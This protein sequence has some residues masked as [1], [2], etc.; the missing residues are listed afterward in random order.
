MNIKL[1]EPSFFC[2]LTFGGGGGVWGSAVSPDGAVK[3][4]VKEAIGFARA[5]GG[6]K[7]GTRL[8]LN[9]HSIRAGCYAYWDNTGVFSVDRETDVIVA[10]AP[11][12]Y[13]YEDMDPKRPLSTVRLGKVEDAYHRG[14]TD[15]DYIIKM[16]A[17]KAGRIG[18]KVHP[19]N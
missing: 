16:N 5:F 11:I 8:T 15:I 12:A 2:Q 3:H 10:Y 19:T 4:C 1:K 6:F 18:D 17:E 9:V 13:R 7:P 14:R